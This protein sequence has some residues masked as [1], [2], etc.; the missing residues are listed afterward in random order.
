MRHCRF[1]AK[2]A[3]RGLNEARRTS[4][5]AFLK[6]PR[7]VASFIETKNQVLG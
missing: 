6:K 4:G 5:A 1:H 7:A 2:L 3:Y